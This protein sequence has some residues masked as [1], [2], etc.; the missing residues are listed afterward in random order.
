MF[1]KRQPF[2][3]RI[4]LCDEPEKYQA[5]AFIDMFL[6]RFAKVLAVGLSLGIT[7]FFAGFESV[8]WLS[9]IVA[10]ILVFWIRIVRFAGREFE[11][12]SAPAV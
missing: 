6:Q 4:H 9:L 11:K 7:T 3:A 8:R 10:T 12:R 5:K 2:S 1:F